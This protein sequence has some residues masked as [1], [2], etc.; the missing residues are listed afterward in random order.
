VNC[1]RCNAWLPP[2]S[3]ECSD[4]EQCDYR[5]AALLRKVREANKRE[6]AIPK[7]KPLQG[8]GDLLP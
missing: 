6:L 1:W 8:Q 2:G 3:K 7:R 4:R 5:Q